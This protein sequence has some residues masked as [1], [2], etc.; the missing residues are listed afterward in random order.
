MTAEILILAWLLIGAL[1]DLF[2][3][4]WY[5]YKCKIACGKSKLVIYR[6]PES[7]IMTI[8]SSIFGIISWVA[9]Y[10]LYNG[11]LMKKKVM[12]G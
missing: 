9:W 4:K 5:V 8:F 1:A 6:L 10:I 3:W 2:W 12:R 7:V 11:L